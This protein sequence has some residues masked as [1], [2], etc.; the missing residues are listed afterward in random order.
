VVLKSHKCHWF[1]PVDTLLFSIPLIKDIHGFQLKQSCSAVAAAV[2]WEGN[3]PPPPM[4]AESYLAYSFPVFAPGGRS[5]L[6]S[7][8]ICH[9]N[10][11]CPRRPCK[12]PLS[13][14]C[15]V[16]MSDTKDSPAPIPLLA[17]AFKAGTQ[18]VL[19]GYGNHLQP[20]MEKVVS[21]QYTR[22]VPAPRCGV[23]QGSVTPRGVISLISSIQKNMM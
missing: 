19:L 18:T 22:L 11:A 20:V 23:R 10:P 9:F 17:A 8:V 21:H 4:V 15:T 3:P 14:S 1:I 2:F 13:P 5:L 12:K 6:V 7:A 16:Q